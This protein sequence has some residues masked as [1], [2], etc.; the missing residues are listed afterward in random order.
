MIYVSRN[1]ITAD[2]KQVEAILNLYH[3]T[4]NRRPNYGICVEGSEFNRRLCIA[5][6]LYKNNMSFTSPLQKADGQILFEILS[7]IFR[8]HHIRIS[9]T[10]FENLIVHLVTPT[11]GSAVISQCSI[12][13][14]RVQNAPVSR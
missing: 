8:V 2:L 12:P 4:I 6:C 3:L 11:S 7:V 1:T 14:A 13:T 9:E 10:S 5:N